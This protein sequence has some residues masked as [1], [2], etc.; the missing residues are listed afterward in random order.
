MEDKEEEEAIKP[1]ILPPLLLRQDTNSPQ[2]LKL[3]VGANRSSRQGDS[4]GQVALH[5]ISSSSPMMHHHHR[6]RS[7]ILL[8]RLAREDLLT[9]QVGPVL[10]IQVDRKE[11]EVSRRHQHCQDSSSREVVRYQTQREVSECMYVCMYVC[12]YLV[13][14]MAMCMFVLVCMAG[15]R[16]LGWDTIMYNQQQQAQSQ[17]QGA[18]NVSQ[19]Q[20]P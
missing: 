6:H 1:A 20:T 18:D 17:G 7:N 3:Q 11:G 15:P 5:Q 12:T 9:Y 4:C 8:H 16:P 2:H 10:D 19:P 14:H 13:T